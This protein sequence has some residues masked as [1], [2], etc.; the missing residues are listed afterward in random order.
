MLPALV[1]AAAVAPAPR[2]PPDPIAVPAAA[3]VPEP[4]VAE[5]PPSTTPSPPAD[6]R[7][8]K[9]ERRLKAVERQNRALRTEVEALREDHDEVSERV[10]RIMPLTGRLGGYLDFGFFHVQGDGS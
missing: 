6:D 2:A 4:V 8:E 1:L 3:D 5:P 9:L 10:D 7:L